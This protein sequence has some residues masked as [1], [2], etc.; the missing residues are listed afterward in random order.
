VARELEGIEE[1]LDKIRDV[2]KKYGPS[3]GKT[4]GAHDLSFAH[5]ALTIINVLLRP[6]LLR[7]MKIVNPDV[8]KQ[9]VFKEL[10]RV[11]AVLIDYCN[12]LAQGADVAL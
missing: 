6:V 3:V 8:D 12:I 5:L 10:D 11:Y 9:D 4:D 2:L 7:R 1:L